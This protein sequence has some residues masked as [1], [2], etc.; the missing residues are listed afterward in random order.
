MV[1]SKKS[2]WQY[3]MIKN[4]IQLT[5]KQKNYNSKIACL[6]LPII[7]VSMSLIVGASPKIK[8]SY[9][10][11][12]QTLSTKQPLKLLQTS[13]KIKNPSNS[14]SF[15]FLKAE[16]SQ[17]SNQTNNFF[18]RETEASYQKSDVSI[19]LASRTK[20]LSSRANE[21]ENEFKQIKI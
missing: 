17:R 10:A 7:V 13:S 16:Y 19:K 11:K 18:H 14:S 15:R 1:L 4:F 5:F 2:F 20:D 8:L 6:L 9:F 3:H 21:L 12:D